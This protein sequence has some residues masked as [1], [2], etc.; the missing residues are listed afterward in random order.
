MKPNLDDTNFMQ[1]MKDLLDM[2]AEAVEKVID[3]LDAKA[4]MSL[5]DAVVNGDKET[6]EQIIGEVDLDTDEVNSLFRGKDIKPTKS[7]GAKKK[8]TKPP[9]DHTFAIGDDV[10]IKTTNEDTGED[11]FMSATVFKP[12]APGD[13]IGVKIEGKP[14]MV[15]KDEV[16]TLNEMV[17]G[18]TGVPDIQR[19]QQ[20][21][22]IQMPDVPKVEFKPTQ[23]EQ[24]TQDSMDAVQQAMNALDTLE[25]VLPDIRLGDLKTVR[26]RIID[27]Q[28]KMNE[29][30][31]AAQPQ[32]RAKKL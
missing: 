11:E 32:G 18:M 17:L 31:M 24:P 20:L 2:D 23:S 26:G 29:S 14:K 1:G 22:G 21:A 25:A 16:Y 7:K 9:E 19:M 12:E 30:I 8:P 6:A 3:T 10:A 13:T 4:L 28:N 15:K 27:M 5:T